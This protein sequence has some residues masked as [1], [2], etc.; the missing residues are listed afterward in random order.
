MSWVRKRF[1]KYHL[2]ASSVFAGLTKDKEGNQYNWEDYG[3]PR[4]ELVLCLLL[5]WILVCL[6]LIKGVSSLGKAAYVITLSPYFVLTAL[7]AY[8]ATLEG[9]GDGIMYFLTP[10]WEKLADINIW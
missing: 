9:A 6:I 7:I 5:T 1:H 3:T 8:A 10:E 4:W 2:Y